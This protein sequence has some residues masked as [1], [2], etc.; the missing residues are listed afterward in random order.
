[1]YQPKE[2]LIFSNLSWLYK[3]CVCLLNI[4][5]FYLLLKCLSM[6]YYAICMVIVPFSR[7]IKYGDIELMMKI[8]IHETNNVLLFLALIVYIKYLVLCRKQSV[9]RLLL[10]INWLV[11]MRNLLKFVLVGADVFEN[12]ILT[13][14]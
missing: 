6:L 14:P 4:S 9:S 8:Q 2:T 10:Y 7:K 13:F 5:I 11:S 1:M 12:I 3:F